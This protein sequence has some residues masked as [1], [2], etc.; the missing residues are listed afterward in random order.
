LL[1]PEA[2]IAPEGIAVTTYAGCIAGMRHPNWEPLREK[3]KQVLML[4]QPA[5]MENR[6][7]LNLIK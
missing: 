2:A 4:L 5:I 6:R 7:Y 1:L 3:A